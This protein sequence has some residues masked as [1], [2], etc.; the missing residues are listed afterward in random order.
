[1]RTSNNDYRTS[2]GQVTV[3]DTA[4]PRYDSS[5]YSDFKME[6]PVPVMRKGS[7]KF[8]IQIQDSNG[9]VLANSDY[10]YF[11]VN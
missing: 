10:E 2:D 7:N 1:M 5:N 4:T 11:S 3:Q 6:I 9:N 8:R